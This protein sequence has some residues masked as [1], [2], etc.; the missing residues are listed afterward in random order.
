MRLFHG[1]EKVVAE[2]KFG[3]GN[4]FNDYGLGFYC[5]E[6]AHMACEWAVRRGIDGFV[7]E[8]ELNTDNLRVLDLNGEEF[9][10]MHWLCVLLE[11]RGFSAGTPLARQAKAYICETFPVGYEDCDAIAGYRADDSYFS[12]ARAFL[13]G[14]ISC[15]QL[16][17]AMHL[18]KLGQQ[19]ALK[20]ARAFDA[21][22]FC[23]AKPC[24]AADWHPKAARRDARA[25]EDF[26]A[27]REEAFDPDGLYMPEILQKR[28][29]PGSARLIDAFSGE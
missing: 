13:G 25:R 5:T 3:A 20:S 22:E 23:G 16:A 12:F 24:L 2:P 21:I 1:S 11:N 27:M 29:G 19:V 6:H 18:G 4:P 17:R 28:F 14:G 7:N 26:A 8:Y 15:Q 10:M 9:T